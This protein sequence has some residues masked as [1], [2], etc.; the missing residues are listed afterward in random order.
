[1]SVLDQGIANVQNPAYAAALLTGFVEGYRENHPLRSGAPLPYLFVAVPMLLQAEI[2]NNI[3]STQ[4]GLRGMVRKLSSS[5]LASTDVVL[6]IGEHALDFRTLTTEALAIM[7]ASRLVVLAA[8]S[9]AVLPMKTN[10][11]R[12][13]ELPRDYSTAVKLGKWF[14][15]LSMFEIASVLKVTF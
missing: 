14:S 11:S 5:E 13:G 6:S 12:R 7:L 10:L 2:V 15:E 8:E 3:R 1:M 9:G 4:L